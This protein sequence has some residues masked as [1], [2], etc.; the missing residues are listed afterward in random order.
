LKSDPSPQ[1]P[2]DEIYDPATGAF[3]STVL[4]DLFSRM[5]FTLKDLLLLGDIDL[6]R[7]AGGKLEAIWF[8]DKRSLKSR[9]KFTEALA[10]YLLNC[11]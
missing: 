7:D 8:T 1:F 6:E 9:N 5:C 3:D 11:I 4:F 2:A 10:M